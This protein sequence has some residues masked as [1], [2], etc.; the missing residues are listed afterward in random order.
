MKEISSNGNTQTVDVIFPFHPIA[1]YANP[2]LLRYMLE[3]LFINQ[4]ANHW[5]YEFSIHDLGFTFPNATGHANGVDEMQPLVSLRI[6]VR[7]ASVLEL[8]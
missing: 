5:P 3:P 4:G 6:V 7:P 8:D 1:I 2:K